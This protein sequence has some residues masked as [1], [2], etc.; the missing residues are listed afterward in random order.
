VDRRRIDTP[1][2]ILDALGHKIK[3]PTPLPRGGWLSAA[4]MAGFGMPGGVV[5]QAGR[6]RRLAQAPAGLDGLQTA[7][8][9]S[10]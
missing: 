9:Q 7:A 1:A 8:T 10:H 5:G 4:G 6:R 2:A 3:W